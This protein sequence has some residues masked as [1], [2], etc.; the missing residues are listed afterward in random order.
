MRISDW[1]SNVCSSDLVGLPNG[2]TAI[3]A[4]GTPPTPCVSPPS[5]KEITAMTKGRL[6]SA[7]PLSMR[8]EGHTSELQSLMRISYQ[9]YCF[10]NKTYYDTLIHH[11]PDVSSVISKQTLGVLHHSISPH[12]N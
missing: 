3:A 9:V 1:S 4:S 8:S 6:G 12:Y 5:R 7:R 11:T 2:K 10:K